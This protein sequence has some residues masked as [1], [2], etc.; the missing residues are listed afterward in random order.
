MRK[1]VIAVGVVFIIIQL[2]S[3]LGILEEILYRIG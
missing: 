1:T 3:V 2:Y